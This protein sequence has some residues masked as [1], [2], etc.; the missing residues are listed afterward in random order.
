MRVIHGIWARETLCLWAEDP[1][2]PAAPGD[3][4]SPSPAPHPFACQAAEL[5]D[6]LADGL[7]ARGGDL[8]LGGILADDMG[9]GKTIQLLPCV[10]IPSQ[11]CLAC[12]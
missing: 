5:A 9:L 11:G 6:V 4:R 1:V 3:G 12:W 8:G 2:L 7:A 10:S